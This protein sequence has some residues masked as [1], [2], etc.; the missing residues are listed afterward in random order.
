MS[1]IFISTLDIS[2]ICYGSPRTSSSR[3]KW[4]CE[5]SLRFCMDRFLAS[6]CGSGGAE[7]YTRKQRSRDGSDGCCASFL[8]DG[9]KIGSATAGH[10]RNIWV[11]LVFLGNEF[12][13]FRTQ[14]TSD[15]FNLRR[16][17]NSRSS[18]DRFSSMSANSSLE[19]RSNISC[20]LRR[21]FSEI[22]FFK[23]KTAYEVQVVT[24]VQT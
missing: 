18:R 15:I 2:G 11:L 7:R 20:E 23:Q 4:V 14:R 19:R 6:P 13:S 9:Q 8:R 12:W 3:T 1:N 16:L 22:F 5:H 24:G 17:R 10:R 21:S